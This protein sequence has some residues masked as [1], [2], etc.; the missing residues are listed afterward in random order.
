M[1][2]RQKIIE[3]KYDIPKNS[4]PEVYDMLRETFDRFNELYNS[5]VPDSVDPNNYSR[6]IV[7]RSNMRTKNPN[8]MFRLFTADSGMY[9]EPKNIF[10]LFQR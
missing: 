8:G 9:N 1:N 5:P 10:R 3:Y 4:D 2:A 6:K 7:V